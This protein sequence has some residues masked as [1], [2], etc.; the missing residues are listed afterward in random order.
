MDQIEKQNDTM[1]TAN[2]DEA[3]VSGWFGPKVTFGLAYTGSRETGIY[4]YQRIN[5]T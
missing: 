4:V 5:S 3:E 1:V 2:D